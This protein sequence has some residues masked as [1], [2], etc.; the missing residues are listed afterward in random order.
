MTPKQQFTSPAYGPGIC[1]NTI[2]VVPVISDS[3]LTLGVLSGY[4]ILLQG[5]F[6]HGVL[7]LAAA[8]SMPA[9][10]DSCRSGGMSRG[11]E[12]NSSAKGFRAVCLGWRYVS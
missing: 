1:L 9:I 3:V 4:S 12:S 8:Q 5:G 2:A 10:G 6:R 7:M 11:R